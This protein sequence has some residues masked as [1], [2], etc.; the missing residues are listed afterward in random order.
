MITVLGIGPGRASLRLNGSQKWVD[1]ADLVIG[2]RRQLDA[3]DTS[4]ATEKLFTKL[5]ELK[6]TIDD[7]LANGKN[8]VILASGDPILYGIGNWTIAQFGR[9][10]VRLVPG[11]S[12]IQYMF[13]TVGLSMNDV[14]LT[15]S[16]GRVPDFDFLLTHRVVGMVTDSQIG[17]FEIGEAIKKRHLHRTI[18]VGERLSYPDERISSYTESTVEKRDYQMNVVIIKDE[19]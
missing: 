5:S 17:P 11:I 12:S 6:T 13:N 14:Y 1:Q 7:W 4:Q 15:S 9:D 19:G 3:F 18:L 2:S 10:A 16:H 8:V